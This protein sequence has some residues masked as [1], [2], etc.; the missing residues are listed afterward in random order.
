MS[1]ATLTSSVSSEDLELAKSFCKVDGTEEDD[2]MQ[3][4]ILMARRDI[5]GQVGSEIDDFFDDNK[6]F[7]ISVCMKV[8]HN[9]KNRDG[10]TRAMTWDITDGYHSLIN[11]MKDEYRVI[12]WKREQEDGKQT[13]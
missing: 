6:T 1:I 7:T 13:Y 12:L 5:I 3:T 10:T 2:L 8:Y 9:Y 11:S 4:L